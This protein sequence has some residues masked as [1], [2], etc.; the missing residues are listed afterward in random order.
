MFWRDF[1]I[2]T[3]TK[4]ASGKITTHFNSYNLWKLQ[5]F[6]Y[7]GTRSVWIYQ[8]DGFDTVQIRLIIFNVGEKIMVNN[9]ALV[10]GINDYPICH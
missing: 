2:T 5:S 9:K 10:V 4:N 1:Y 8:T 3:Y 6:M 7:Q